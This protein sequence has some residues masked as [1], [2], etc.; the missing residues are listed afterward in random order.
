MSTTIKRVALVAVAALSLG[1]VSV[2]PS[3]AYSQ[4]DSLVLSAATATQLTSETATATSAV[5][6]LTYLADSL[7]DSMSVTA[8][9]VS[10]PAG[11]VA[12]PYLQLV[13]TSSAQAGN[14]NVTA[15]LPGAS[16][17]PNK[18]ALVWPTDAP[19]SSSAKF[20]VFIGTSA[21]AA[22]T[23]AGTYVVKLTPAVVAGGGS[24][25]S[26]A[27][28]VTI[29]VTKAAA[30]DTVAT[31][32]NS[33]SYIG[34]G[35]TSTAWT[36]GADEVVTAAKT[37][38]STDA[39]AT[40]ILTQKNAAGSGIA[41]TGGESLTV[42]VAGP[43]SISQIAA[44][45]TMNGSGT[46]ARALTLKAGNALQVFS[47]GS[48]GVSTITFANAA[49]TVIA[50]ESLTFYSTVAAKVV[51]T[52]K[53][54]YVKAGGLATDGNT[55]ASKTE[56]NSRVFFVKVYDA[57]GVDMG[58]AITPTL[59]G[60]TATTDGL[61]AK[62]GVCTY[63]STA[64]TTLAIGFYCSA[65]GVSATAFGKASYTITATNA[66]DSV[67][68]T[69]AEVTF[70]DVVATKITITGPASAAVGEKVTLTFTATE[71]NG[72]PVADASYEG[73]ATLTQGALFASVVN[74]NSAFAPFA[75]GD[76]ITTV[77]GV[78]TRDVYLPV[79][80]GSV[81][82]T[83]T[84]T[85]TA[86][87]ASG[88]LASTL[89]AGTVSVTVGV[90]NPGVDAAT[91]AAN[92]AAQAASDATDAALAAADAADA[93]TTKAQEAVDA[94]ATLSAQVSKLITAL[95][96]QITTLTNLVIKI[97]KKVKA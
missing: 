64:T 39:A 71:K 30:L 27:Q 78:A 1:V 43:G 95:K 24:L 6:T 88:A 80:A 54:A 57:A 34:A 96:A 50:T 90:S 5:A 26:A 17:D 32:A 11:N 51:A 13:E 21:T 91:D 15:I 77:S 2:A 29:T 97:Q 93:A 55:T 38:N 20:K 89:T 44:G 73:N 40:I 16:V 94:V 58:N 61:L 36:L 18:A 46:G 62:A 23:L 70:A 31:A 63:Q 47:D 35:E 28:T 49:G 7:T 14:G 87:T 37:L 76:T 42:T 19:A 8:S 22:P 4:S 85:G 3:Q 65:P 82:S 9:L 48:A 33:T 86:G 74:S 59:K 41:V 68:T 83:W 81:T 79:A 25:V 69:T 12:L 56:T 60:T 92:E 10:A 52:V 53:K 84:L 75:V 67:A 45:A 66:D 72:Y